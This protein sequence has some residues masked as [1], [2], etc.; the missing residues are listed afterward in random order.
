MSTFTSWDSE[1]YHHGIKGMTWGVRRYQN[2]DGSLTAAGRAHYGYG[3][4]LT[5][6]GQRAYKKGYKKLQK[7]NDR[8]NINLQAQKAQKYDKR[9]K[10]AAKIGAGLGIASIANELGG[11]RIVSKLAA[12]KYNAD[13]LSAK[14]ALDAE[15]RSIRKDFH[16]EQ[17]FGTFWAN[18]QNKRYESAEDNYYNALADSRKSGKRMASTNK[19]ITYGLAAASAVSLG[20][21]GYNKVKSSLAKKRMSEVGHAKAVAKAKAQADK[22]Q[23]MFGNVKISDIIKE[24]KKKK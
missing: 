12:N 20:V 13:K 17:P 1:L 4:G 9:A 14:A 11:S 18:Y 24:N 15:Y 2:P 7:L 6:A 3:E 10:T 21:A 22:M 5:R 8:A 16:G 19:A 23:K